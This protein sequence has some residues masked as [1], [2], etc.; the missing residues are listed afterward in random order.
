MS[1]AFPTGSAESTVLNTTTEQTNFGLRLAQIAFR[2]RRRI[3]TALAIVCALFLGFHVIFG[4]NGLTVY[5]QKRSDDK[6]LSKRIQELQQENVRLKAHTDR[7]QADSGAIE[8]E[9]R[10]KLHY[11][12]PGEV[13]YTLDDKPKEEPK[14][15]STSN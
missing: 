14:A 11:A 9:A 2:S 3:A 1:P 15:P 8:H 6:M 13:I 10:E 5:Q 4:Q 12:R 7:L